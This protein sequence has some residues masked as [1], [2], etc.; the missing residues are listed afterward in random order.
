MTLLDRIKQLAQEQNTNLKNLEIST[1][2]GNGTIRR[3][4]NSPPS[5]DKLQK[6]ANQL[7]TTI[8]YL[9]NGKEPNITPISTD[10][11]NADAEWLALIHQLPVDAQYEFRGEIKGYLKRMNEE[12]VAA[13]QPRKMAK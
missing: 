13:D 12:S 11:S 1:G 10:V 9:V 6:I 7:N 8:D 4:D 3:W 2:L 5:V